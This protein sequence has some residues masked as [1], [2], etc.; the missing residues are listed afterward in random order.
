MSGKHYIFDIIVLY[1]K[2]CIVCSSYMLYFC[3]EIIIKTMPFIVN[4]WFNC[5]NFAKNMDRCCNWERWWVN[6]RWSRFHHRDLLSVTEFITD[7]LDYARSSDISS[8]RGFIDPWL[9]LFTESERPAF[10]AELENDLNAF[11]LASQLGSISD[12]GQK[13]T[14][15]LVIWKMLF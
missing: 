11:H 5:K 1:T 2:S 9:S 14:R 15:S 8:E 3:I 7:M 10:F 13:E 12:I 6:T 4:L